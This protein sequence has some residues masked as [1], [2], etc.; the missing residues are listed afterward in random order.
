MSS[1]CI[2]HVFEAYGQGSSFARVNSLF[3]TLYE[4]N[5]S[6]TKI[7]LL[8]LRIRKGVNKEN[9]ESRN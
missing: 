2:Q 4:M 1:R 8:K 6:T 9:K 7:L 3:E 5:A